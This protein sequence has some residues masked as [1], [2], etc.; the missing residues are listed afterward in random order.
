[1]Q[2]T[3]FLLFLVTAIG[4]GTFALSPS[5]ALGQIEP[6]NY[7]FSLDTLGDFYPG[8]KFEAIKQKYGK[9]EIE[10]NKG[11]SVIYKFYVSHIRYKFPVF[12]NVFKGESVGFFAR[13]PSY[14]LHDV[15]HQSLINRY[16]KQDEYSKV[17]NAANYTWNN[18]NNLKIIYQGQCTLTCFP[19]YISG[20]M[21]APPEGYPGTT[22]I[23]KEFGIQNYSSL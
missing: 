1:M 23:L 3:F 14:F 17:G 10:F 12:V 18:K 4:I 16:G 8:K 15:F 22:D 20:E 13:L 5:P 7:N 2:K 19:M 9:G 11:A 21:V 6:P